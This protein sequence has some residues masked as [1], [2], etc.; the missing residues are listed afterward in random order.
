M[1]FFNRTN[2][3]WLSVC[4]IL[5]VYGYYYAI[6]NTIRLYTI[7]WTIFIGAISGFG[8]LVGS[9]RLWAHKSFKA[10]WLVRCFL[11]LAQTIAVNGSVFSYARDH[12]VHHKFTDTRAD[13]KNAS[14]GF[15]FAHMGWWM[16]KK[17]QAVID[18]GR[19][20]NYDN[21]LNDFFVRNQHK[22]YIPLVIIFW[23]VIP[24]IVPYCFWGESIQV[25]ILICVF[26]RYVIVLNHM[27][28]VNSLAHLYGS[29]P[30][31]S[32]MGP[33]ENK[34]VIYLSMGEGYHNYHHI[35]PYDYRTSNKG[36]IYGFNPA[37]VFIDTCYL[38]GLCYDLKKT[39]K[40]FV[41]NRINRT[42]KPE[43]F[44]NIEKMSKTEK[45][46]RGIIDWII[47]SLVVIWPLYPAI[48]LKM[49]YL[50]MNGVELTAKNVVNY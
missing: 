8:V 1:T 36:F 41:K 29:R 45:I 47:G 4:H 39:P 22:Y 15:F 13:P 30:F 3:I 44:V 2:V 43:K 48:A 12:Q 14:K 18:E 50:Y 42:G 10:H 23:G 16:V 25:S 37:T 46:I 34:L 9:H 21:M 24:A 26:F 19:K 31:D 20:L 7:I 40:D 38:L 35:F 33:A 49:L 28:T 27:F 32:S 17:D 5:A 11:V 6:V